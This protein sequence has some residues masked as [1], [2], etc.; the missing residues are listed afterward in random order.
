MN[1]ARNGRRYTYNGRGDTLKM[2]VNF[3]R[4]VLGV[5]MAA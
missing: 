5:S 3:F 4:S 1:I 2:C